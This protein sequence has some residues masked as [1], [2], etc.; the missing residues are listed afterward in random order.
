MKFSPKYRTKKLG[1][2]YTIL[3]SFWPFVIGKGQILGPKSGLGKIPTRRQGLSLNS[4][5]CCDTISLG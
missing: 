3:G 4:S 1:M 2:M 5:I